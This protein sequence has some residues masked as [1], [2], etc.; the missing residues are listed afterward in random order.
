[1]AGSDQVVVG[2]IVHHEGHDDENVAEAVSECGN[3]DS[4]DAFDHVH[5]DETSQ[6]DLPAEGHPLVKVRAIVHWQIYSWMAWYQ[7]N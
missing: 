4:S 5:L 3:D 7:R 1:M 6:M 2:D